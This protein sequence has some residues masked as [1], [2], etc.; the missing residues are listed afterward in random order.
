MNHSWIEAANALIASGFSPS[1]ASVR[2]GADSVRGGMLLPAIVSGL[3]MPLMLPRVGATVRRVFSAEPGHAIETV[4]SGAPAQSDAGF[5][6]S[7][8]E[9]S[10]KNARLAHELSELKAAY[11]QLAME[12]AERTAV[13][14][15]L[16]HLAH[17]D[18][19]TQLPNR[20]LLM[21]RLGQAL[22]HARR[23]DTGVLVIYLDLDNFK[24]INDTMGH[25]AGDR[26]LGEIGTR[27]AG[28]MRSADTASRIGGDEFVLICGTTDPAAD[29]ARIRSRLSRAMEAPI[30]VAGTPVTIGASIGV[31]AFPADGSD[32]AELIDKADRA[33]YGAKSSGRH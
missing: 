6:D 19:L 4:R 17:H 16:H 23:A 24:T 33:M 2:F 27:I 3:L 20:V 18:P 8:L 11:A 13:A 10:R 28:C 21:D 25:A 26:V 14:D 15:R 32:A 31:S 12:M 30:D 9:M 7:L 29:A 5:D 22:A 1:L